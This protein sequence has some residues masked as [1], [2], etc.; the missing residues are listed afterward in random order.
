MSFPTYSPEDKREPLSMQITVD[1]NSI[2]GDTSVI[3]NLAGMAAKSLKERLPGMIVRE[4]LQSAALGVAQHQANKKLGVFGSTMVTA[5]DTA[6]SKADLRSIYS[7]PYYIQCFR[8]EID[9][10][11]HKINLS[12]SGFGSVD[13]DLEIKPKSFTIIRITCIGDTTMYHKVIQL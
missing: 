10:G 13:L 1:S 2:S 11:I 3:C 7:F 8:T 6:I 4:I 9:P 12:P 5:I